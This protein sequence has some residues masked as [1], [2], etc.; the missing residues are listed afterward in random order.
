MPI[1]C[2]AP[3]ESCAG[4]LEEALAES[5]MTNF[6]CTWPTTAAAGN[7][8]A[9]TVPPQVQ[10]LETLNGG[11]FDPMKTVA[12]G[13]NPPF[14]ESGVPRSIATSQFSEA[15]SPVGSLTSWPEPDILRNSPPKM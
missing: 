4:G 6:P 13:N 8:A 7:D 11:K 15:R 9:Q 10:G 3:P 2:V 1:G 12:L 14:D 5:K